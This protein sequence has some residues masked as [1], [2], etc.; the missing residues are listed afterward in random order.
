[1][2]AYLFTLCYKRDDTIHIDDKICIS[3]HHSRV[4]SQFHIHHHQ[5]LF[6]SSIRPKSHLS[7]YH[8]SFPETLMLTSSYK[9]LLFS[10]VSPL[11]KYND[12]LSIV[13]L[14]APGLF[15]WKPKNKLFYFRGAHEL[16][17]Q[18]KNDLKL[19]N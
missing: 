9:E 12:S 8:R 19:N 14:I 6:Y 1:M 15:C 5:S 10:I 2:E 13:V 3:F 11:R 18:H 16:N 7:N 17:V 4:S